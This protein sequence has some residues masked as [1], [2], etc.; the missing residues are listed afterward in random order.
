MKNRIMKYI[1]ISKFFEEVEKEKI[2]REH[3]GYSIDLGTLEASIKADIHYLGES[4][5]R[6]EKGWPCVLEALEKK[7]DGHSELVDKI[8]QHRTV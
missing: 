8:L 7:V 3:K 1:K 5:R 6:G 2:A 4:L